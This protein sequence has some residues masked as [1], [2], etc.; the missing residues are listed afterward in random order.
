MY[1]VANMPRFS[2]ELALAMP[3][4]AEKMPSVTIELCISSFH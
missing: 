4:A 1:A 2:V 3:Q